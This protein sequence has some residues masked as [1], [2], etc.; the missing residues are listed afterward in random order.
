MPSLPKK[1]FEGMTIVECTRCVMNS[2]VDPDLVLSGGVCQHCI[3]YD[4]LLN[5]RIVPPDQRPKKLAALVKTI[6]KAGRKS[7]YDCI[8]GVS[9]GVDSSYVALQ[10]KRLGL[11]PLAVH[12]DNGWNSA[13]AVLNIERLLKKLDIDL[14]TE[15]LRLDEFYDLQRAFLHAST[16]DA[17]IPADHAIQ[18]TLWQVARRHGIRYVMSGMNFATESISVPSWSYG[19]SDWRYIR[20]VHRKFGRVHLK[21]YPHYGFAVLGWTT[22]VRRIRIA[23]ILN[24][25]N[26][27]KSRAMAELTKEL[28]WVPYAGKH[29]ESIYTRWVQGYYLPKKFNIDKRYGHYS[30]LINSGL[31]D[32]A[33]A[34][35]ALQEVNYDEKQRKDDEM[36]LMKKLSISENQLSEILSKTPA[37]FREYRNSYGFVQFMR[38]TVNKLRRMGLYPR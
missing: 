24:Y 8:V 18:A 22:F 1:G 4:Q 23:S 26:F 2:L 17:D 13:L 12:V 16:P 34:I 25:L 11:R 10:V 6:S 5:S 33:T 35:T 37:S 28:G 38:T 7:E 20:D 15:V 19:H 29:Y 31:I 36:L 32:R 27:D 21:T 9:G 14:Y 30:D 3:R